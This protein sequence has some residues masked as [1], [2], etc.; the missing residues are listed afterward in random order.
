MLTGQQNDRR[1]HGL[2]ISFTSIQTIVLS[3]R[4]IG[5]SILALRQGA[6]HA[7]ASIANTARLVRT[8]DDWCDV[9]TRE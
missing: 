3:L 6:F 7:K 9:P 8:G 4:F 1:A 5:I 2:K